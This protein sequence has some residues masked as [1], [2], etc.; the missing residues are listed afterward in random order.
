VL[1]PCRQQRSLVDE[2]R[3]IRA[4]HA[5]RCRR[6]PAEV[7]IRPKWDASSVHLE[8]RLST[9]TIGRRHCNPS[10]E[11][12]R[13]KQRLVEDIRAVGRADDDHVR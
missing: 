8:D 11:P 10:I 12:A 3:Q 2:I 9:G 4:D 7:D 5:G 13:S 1:P 6:D